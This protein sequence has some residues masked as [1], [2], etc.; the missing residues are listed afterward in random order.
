MQVSRKQKTFSQFFPAFH[1]SSLYFEHFLKKMTRR[2]D[3][4]PKLRKQKNLVRSMPIKSR[5]K[6]SFEKQHGKRA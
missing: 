4:F 5:F 2:A 6:G 1:Q 3:V